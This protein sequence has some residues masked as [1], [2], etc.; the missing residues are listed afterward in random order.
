MHAN[1]AS[2][3]RVPAALAGLAGLLALSGCM[4]ARIEESRE[5]QTRIADDEAVVILAKPQIEGAAAEEEFMDCVSRGLGSGSGG[6]LV[7]DNNSFV[8]SKVDHDII[9]I[10][11]SKVNNDNF[12]NTDS[13]DF[14]D[15]NMK[16]DY[17]Y[18][19]NHGRRGLV[20]ITKNTII[21]LKS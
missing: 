1:A 18:N 10:V 5:L 7:R 13:M 15:G 19:M 3:R 20:S 11:D 17:L 16:D 14:V 9:D 21:D 8:D 2:L 6:L 4:H 12:D